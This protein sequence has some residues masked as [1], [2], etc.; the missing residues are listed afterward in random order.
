MLKHVVPGIVGMFL[1]F[2]LVQFAGPADAQPSSA[3][4]IGVGTVY[5]V[6][7]NPDGSVVAFHIQ[8]VPFK[9]FV[10]DGGPGAGTLWLW[11]DLG[12]GLFAT[13]P[14]PQVV[15]TGLIKVTNERA[16]GG[17]TLGGPASQLGFSVTSQGGQ[18]QCQFAGSF[19]AHFVRAGILVIQSDIHGTVTPGTFTT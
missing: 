3:E 18:F 16:S 5:E 1:L 13:S 7:K 2:A 8:K 9:V 15:D 17:G 10:T 12:E 6:G 11:I 4:F 14:S 19:A